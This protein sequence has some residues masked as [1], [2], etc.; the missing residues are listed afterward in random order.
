LEFGPGG[1]AQP[2]IGPGLG[3]KVNEE[4]LERLTVIREEM[5]LS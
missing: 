4:A 3:I 2:L 5:A 1:I